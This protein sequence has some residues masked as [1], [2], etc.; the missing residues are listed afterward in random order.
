[1]SSCASNTETQKT[2]PPVADIKPAVEPAYPVEALQPGPDG[3]AAE[4]AWWNLE[5]IWGRG[6]HDK[7]V[8]ICHW[9]QD[10]KMPLPAGYCG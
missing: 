3:Q 2:F 10:L 9:A 6:E 4:Q 1:V 5:L 8:R 7:V